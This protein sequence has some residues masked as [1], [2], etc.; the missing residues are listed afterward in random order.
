MIRIS[1]LI[2]AVSITLVTASAH[3]SSCDSNTPPKLDSKIAL[4]NESN[5]AI[6]A[7]D[8]AHKHTLDAARAESKSDTLHM[9]ESSYA[10]LMMLDIYKEGAWRVAYK[11]IADKVDAQYNEIQARFIKTICP[12]KLNLYRH[13][14][15][16]GEA[17]AMYNLGTIY[18]KGSGVTQSD[19]EALTWYML[20]AEKGNLDAYL[21]LGKI[22]SDGAAFKPDY[23]M[24]LDW[25]TKAATSGD[26][27]AQYTIANMYR[28]G[29]GTERDP[30]KAVEWFKKAAEQKFEGA[31]A[32]LEEMYN[33]GEAKRLYW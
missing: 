32:K 17:W 14:A 33:A 7:M 29:L 23:T 2:F 20:A 27:S 25:Y 24:A 22:Y 10:A 30:K 18:A 5:C 8:T 9:C 19:D 1:H 11:Y 12:Q 28:K 31:K 16:K 21:A 26:A 6:K 13:L 15:N 4:Y 3:A